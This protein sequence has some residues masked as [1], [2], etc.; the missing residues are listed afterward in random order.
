[1]DAVLHYLKQENTEV[2]ADG[3]GSYRLTIKGDYRANT[4]SDACPNGGNQEKTIRK[5]FLGG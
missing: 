4:Q 1:M 3:A 2:A 5:I